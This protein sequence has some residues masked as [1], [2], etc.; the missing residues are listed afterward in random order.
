MGKMINNKR[1]VGQLILASSVFVGCLQGAAVAADEAPKPQAK[2]GLTSGNPT[3]TKGGTQEEVVT[4]SDLRDVGLCINQIKQQAINI[5]LD[6]TRKAVP[7]S[8]SAELEDVDE[9]SNAGLSDSSKYLPT[10][11]EW[12]VF[13]VGAM[14]PIIHLLQS[15]VKDVES[16][17]AK[18]MV[19]KGSQEK[20]EKLFDDYEA[21]VAQLNV[22]LTKIYEGIG[23]KNN[24]VKL[25][26]EAVKMY[27]VADDLERSRVEAFQMIKS[28]SGTE[29]E[30]LPRKTK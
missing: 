6:V 8:A 27:E 10:R 24:N 5:Y 26:Q 25:A 7:A 13:Y 14:E 21:S 1:I 18:L 30:E 28:Q 4:L 19:P 11:P 22:H 3:I 2:P 29:L 23:E 16:G 15:D 17:V 9:I 20:F 12:L